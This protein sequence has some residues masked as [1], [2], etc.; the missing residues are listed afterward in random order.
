LYQRHL[1]TGQLRDLKMAIPA[2]R[3]AVDEGVRGEPERTQDMTLLLGLLVMHSSQ[4]SIIS[5]LDAAVR[6]VATEVP[7]IANTDPGK[8]ALLVS[9]AAAHHMRYEQVGSVEDQ[10]TAIELTRQ[11]AELITAHH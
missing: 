6:L 3:M 9:A 11:A 4:A 2:L 10:R 8:P 5:E 7:E 1:A